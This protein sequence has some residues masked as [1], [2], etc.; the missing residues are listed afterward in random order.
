MCRG[1]GAEL[2]SVDLGDERLNNRAVLVLETLASNPSV[3]INA[4]CNGRAETEAAYRLFQNDRVQP[5][6]ILRSHLE[7]TKRRIAEQEVVLLVQDTTELDFS[8][9]PPKDAGCLNREERKGLYDHTHLAVTPHGLS[10]GVVD[11]DLFDRTAESLGQSKERQS[12]PIETKESYRWLMGYRHACELAAASPETQIVSVADRE[13]DIYDIFVEARKQDKPAEFLIRS[14]VQRSLPVKDES[15]GE[16]AYRQMQQ[17][18][19]EAPLRG[20]QQLDLPRTPNREA[21]SATLEIR[22]AAVTLKPPHARSWLPQVDVHVVLVEEVDGPQDGTDVRWLLINSLPI[23]SFQDALQVLD[24]YAARWTIEV[25]FR[26]LKSG[27]R[28]EEIQLETN[29]RLKTALAFY[30]IIAWRVMYLTFLGRECPKLACDV[31]FDQAEWKAVW[32]IVESDPLPATAPTLA[33]F[34]PVLAQLGGYNR[35]NHDPPPG[36]ETLWRALRRMTDFALAWQ[37]FGPDE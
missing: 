37:T 8:N 13:G 21:R 29:D 34:L 19:A 18:V 10:L 25:Y 26:V 33:E 4:A 5:E 2:E 9:H 23:E 12:D 30:H 17:E 31:V 22:T 32:K 1:I 20:T 27:C 3:S 35:R 24:Y 7:V 36:P 28:V 15:A 6:K 11:V 16:A 14:R